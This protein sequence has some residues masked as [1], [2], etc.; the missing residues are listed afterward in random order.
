MRARATHGIALA[1]AAL[2]PAELRATA[3][4]PPPT[5]TVVTEAGW[6]VPE[7]L[8]R[9]GIRIESIRIA[10]ATRDAVARLGS[11]SWSEREAAV[12]AL[13]GPETGRLELYRLLTEGGLDAERR[14]RLIRALRRKLIGTPRGALGI[15]MS[16][17]RVR[18]ITE[19]GVR[20]NELLPRMPAEEVL[21]VGDRILEIDGE[22]VADQDQLVMRV[23]SLAPGTTVRLTVIRERRDADGN[24]DRDEQGQTRTMRIEVPLALGSAE[25]LID[26]N[27]EVQ[28]GGAFLR[29]IEEELR[30]AE[31]AYAP[32]P[33]VLRVP[34]RADL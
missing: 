28:R 10:P 11:E 34:E 18:G 25:A 26:E 22:P 15:R 12:D 21:V 24:L 30:F 13:A 29:Q 17:T 3:Q 16:L 5:I 32:R 33:V 20:V 6:A 9:T 8:L 1:L 2:L 27:G 23:Q 31:V 14:F 7:T 4:E 19:E